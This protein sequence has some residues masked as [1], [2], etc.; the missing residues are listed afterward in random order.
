M[1]SLQLPGKEQRYVRE[2]L[3]CPANRKKLQRA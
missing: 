3:H 1:I 2:K